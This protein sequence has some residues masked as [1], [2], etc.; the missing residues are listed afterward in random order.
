M[1]ATQHRTAS[2]GSAQVIVG[3]IEGRIEG[4]APTQRLRSELSYQDP[5]AAEFLRSG[6]WSKTIKEELDRL[7]RLARGDSVQDEQGVWRTASMEKDGHK[8]AKVAYA[9]A[10]R[11]AHTVYLY[12][13]IKRTFP[14][15]MLRQVLRIMRDS[16]IKYEMVDERA[17]PEP[18]L[19][20]IR[21]NPCGHE[22]RDY[23]DRAVRVGKH[24][25]AG[26]FAMATNSGK[27]DV[28]LR[29]I[30]AR[31]LK[32][33]IVVQR[34]ELMDQIHEDVQ[35]HLGY[36]AG[37]VGGGNC[38]I[39]DITIA[40]VN[41]ANAHIRSLVDY[42]FG[43]VF[44]DEGHHA[45]SRLHFTVLQKLKPYCK[46]SLTGTDFR[47]DA[48]E[49]VILAAAFGGTFFR[50]D[51]QFMVEEGYSAQ[52]HAQIL[53]CKQDLHPRYTWR[54]VYEQAILN[55][56]KRTRLLV[57]AVIEHARAGRTVLVL[58]EQT[59]HGQT[60]HS[61]L[62][63]AGVDA[64]FMH[65]TRGRQERA[66]AR[67]DFRERKFQVLVGTTIYD[68][69][70]DFPTLDV[71]AFAG[72]KKAKGK[73]LQRLGRGQ[74]RG[75]HADGSK[76]DIA[77]LIDVFDTG[78]RLLKKH[79]LRRL[80]AMHDAGVVLPKTYLKLLVKEGFI[81]ANEQEPRVPDGRERPRGQR[82]GRREQ[83]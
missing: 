43:A 6:E 72:G 25:R 31:R 10:R 80:S 40:I 52:L 26:T 77:Y 57:D 63:S 81:Y 50:V 66:A 35:R 47:N 12:E 37:R 46:Y 11:V 13:P 4:D 32:S 27:T 64:R 45:A 36:Y 30:E 54:T 16:G 62:V 38:T 82:R 19:N 8:K 22:Q 5:K 55:S 39:R 9:E 34:Q 78:H 7:G 15:T 51:N 74:R 83:A 42:G 56:L 61:Y 65:G 60:I 67:V 28:M 33:L 41:S 53:E 23:Q 18:Q 2:S 59:D 49:N 75:T 24:C 58:T 71:V 73:V 79:S 20:G 17:P 48:S 76:K 14:I 29:L 21:F 68:E 3:N 69:G 44:V 70:V 1:F